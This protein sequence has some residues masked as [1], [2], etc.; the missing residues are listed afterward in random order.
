MLFLVGVAVRGASGLPGQM[1][2]VVLVSSLWS[3]ALFQ[4]VTWLCLALTLWELP[5]RGTPPALQGLAAR[6]PEVVR[7]AVH[8]HTSSPGR[9]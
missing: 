5:A 1:L 2:V 7:A 3:N 8:P 9:R 4:P 6:L